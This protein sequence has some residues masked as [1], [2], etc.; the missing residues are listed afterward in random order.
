VEGWK[1]L[2][3]EELYNLNTSSSISR[4]IKSMKISWMGHIASMGKMHTKFWFGN[5]KKRDCLDYIGNDGI[6]LRWILRK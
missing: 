5:L 1:T 2:H 4:V 3:N 6:I